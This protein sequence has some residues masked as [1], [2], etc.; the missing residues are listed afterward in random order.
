MSIEVLNV[1]KLRF[2]IKERGLRLNWVISQIGL[3][4][5]VGYLLL[6]EGK[7]P[8]DPARKAR[9]LGELSK[10][11][12]VQTKDLTVTLEAKTA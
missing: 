7:L 2:L 4:Q 1:E 9:V 8:K 3:G 6:R 5:H 12:G 11:F 10:M